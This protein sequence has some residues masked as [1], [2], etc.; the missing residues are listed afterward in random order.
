VNLNTC[1][2]GVVR[3]RPADQRGSGGAIPASS[4]FFHVGFEDDA[5]PLILRYHYSRRVPSAVQFVG[6]FHLAGG[7]FGSRGEC[8]AAVVFS[9]P[10]TRWG[11]TVWELSRL[12]RVGGQR[13]P[14]TKLLALATARIRREG[15]IDLLVSFA[16]WTQRHVGTVY[17]AAGWEYDG[18]REQT[19]D[20]LTVNGTFVPGR[21]RNSLWGTR[22]PD[23]LGVVLPT[24]TI[25]PHYDDGKHLY[26]K[27][28]SAS[29]RAKAARL[30]LRSRA[31]PKATVPDHP[32]PAVP[33]AK[34]NEGKECL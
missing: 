10:G 22:S 24:A 7:L 11:E 30:G 25:E 33:T 27:A 13:V 3:A 5:F 20:G 1:E 16:D 18:K 15:Q 32:R 23:R 19:M 31:Y 28:L 8:V 12:V 9:I 17:Q 6:T 14:L 26:W 4:L 29:G 34:A 2:G 21:S